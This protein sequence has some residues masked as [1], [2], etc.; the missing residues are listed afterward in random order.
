MGR[1]RHIAERS[2]GATL[3]PEDEQA[4][5]LTLLCPF[6]QVMPNP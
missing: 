4:L 5:P 3:Q 1:E 6:E 2:I